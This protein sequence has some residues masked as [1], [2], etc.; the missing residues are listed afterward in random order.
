MMRQGKRK[1]GPMVM[2]HIQGGPIA[3]KELG[4]PEVYISKRGEKKRNETGSVKGFRHFM[5]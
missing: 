3:G 2:H 1:G 4:P 5:Y